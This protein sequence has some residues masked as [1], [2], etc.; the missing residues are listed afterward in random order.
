MKVTAKSFI[1]NLFT[2]FVLVT[3]GTIITARSS[4][5]ASPD[6]LL[7]GAKKSVARVEKKA[8]A[9]QLRWQ[10]K[11]AFKKSGKVNVVFQAVFQVENPEQFAS[12]T[13]EK[14]LNIQNLTINSQAVPVPLKGMRYS[15][16][17][18]VPVSLLKK[19]T[20][21][22]QATWT[23]QV[24]AR[25]DKKTAKISLSPKLI[26]AA[27]LKIRLLGLKASALSFQTGPVLGYAGENF[28]TVSC[29]VNIPARVALKV[30]GKRYASKP[31]LFHSFKAKG[32][33]ADTRYH[34]SLKASLVGSDVV[35]STGPCAVRTLPAGGKFT[36]VILG[37]SRT[38][39]KD[40][41][42]VAQAVAK[43]R[44]AL[45][46]FV[47]DMVTAGRI[48]S[49]WDE[50]FFSP[51]KNFFATIPFFG[52]I[53][54]HEQNCPLFTRIFPTPGDKN[55]S[56]KVGSVLFVGIDG[57]MNW[58]PDSKLAKWL[59][60]VLA[61]SDAKF[62]F[63]ASHYPAWT[64]GHHGRLN[65]DG[66]PREKSLRQAQ[67]VIMPLLK[68]YNATAMFAGHD[69]IY[70]RSEPADGVTMVVTGGAGAP[71]YGKVKNAKKQN[72]HSRAFAAKHH[73]CLLTIDGDTCTMKVF[74]PKG[75]LID[76]RTWAGRK[77]K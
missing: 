30:N 24:R 10:K 71:L 50:Q 72:P 67:D 38:F 21:T 23:Q 13:L 16:I 70:E 36:F 69:H 66:R 44:P 20:N 52:I 35:V 53:G 46:V 49:Q 65:K 68:K 76:T 26:D 33:A 62:V 61:K 37:D 74:T 55:W 34:Y 17:P 40:W 2:F 18:G 42:K 29:R 41:A 15:A 60:G 8:D 7:V 14:P 47:G 54:N 3:I 51:G 48:D 57:A 73:Y 27:K 4:F 22:L 19:G 39:P 77:G 59:D 5:A 6:D 28:F 12:L 25:K 43:T 56:Q 75:E 11:L 45:A 31:A 1:L 9:A 63:L 64:S 58:A 32:L